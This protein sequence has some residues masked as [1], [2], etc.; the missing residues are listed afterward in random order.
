MNLSD[1][2][3]AATDLNLPSGVA[4]V[5]SSASIPKGYIAVRDLRQASRF[6]VMIEEGLLFYYDVLTA[7]TLKIGAHISKKHVMQLGT[8]WAWAEYGGERAISAMLLKQRD[9]LRDKAQ[10]WKRLLRKGARWAIR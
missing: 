6:Y 10:W 5:I 4:H 8:Y 1:Y 9:I 2:H 7:P 3:R